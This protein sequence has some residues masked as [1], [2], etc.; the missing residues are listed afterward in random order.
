MSAPLQ[1]R[2]VLIVAPR[3][4]R[5][6]RAPGHRDLFGSTEGREPVK[7]VTLHRPGLEPGPQQTFAPVREN[8]QAALLVGPPLGQVR[9]P[10]FTSSRGQV[11]CQP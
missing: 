8:R 7:L 3:N 9:K 11:A 2:D 1:Y 5:H 4:A 6:G 10:G